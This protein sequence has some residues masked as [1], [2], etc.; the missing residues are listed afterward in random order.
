MFLQGLHSLSFR[1]GLL[2]KGFLRMQQHADKESAFIDI[3]WIWRSVYAVPDF[4]GHPQRF[5][6]IIDVVNKI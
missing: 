4:N 2:K 6:T 1:S 5:L 3:G